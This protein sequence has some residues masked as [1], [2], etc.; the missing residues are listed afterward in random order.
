MAK[1]KSSKIGLSNVHVA[2]YDPV[3]YKYSKP[4]AIK[5][6]KEMKVS[7]NMAESKEYNDN[8]L[9]EVLDSFD[10]FEIELTFTDLTPEE[11]AMLLGWKSDGAIK[12]SGANDDPPWIALMGER[13]KKDGTKRYFKYFKGKSR[14]DS[15]EASTKGDS[16]S[17]QPDVLK[18]TFG[19]L[20]DDYPVETYKSV[21]RAIVDESDSQYKDEGKTWYDEVIVGQTEDTEEDA[22]IQP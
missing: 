21:A 16:V 14:L 9:F 8:E 6:I 11:Q 20:P 13:I 12:L 15:E 18:I 7:L 22:E 1:K 10:N 17:A 5:T 4:I 19:A 3:T 2:I